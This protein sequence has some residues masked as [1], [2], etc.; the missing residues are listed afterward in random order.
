M[1]T[2]IIVKHLPTGASWASNKKELT[3]EEVVKSKEML[4]RV[5]GGHVEYFSLEVSNEK[6]YFPENVLKD[7]VISL[8]CSLT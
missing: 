6:V 3:E 8:A 5:A 7:C 4:A 1:Q 2:R